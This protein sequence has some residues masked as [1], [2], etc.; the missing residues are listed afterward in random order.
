MPA[1]R[2]RGR[3]PNVA[4]AYSRANTARQRKALRDTQAR[5]LRRGFPGENEPETPWVQLDVLSGANTVG[6]RAFHPRRSHIH[7]R[8]CHRSV[9]ILPRLHVW[10]E[11]SSVRGA[12]PSRKVCGAVRL[13]R[14]KAFV[15]VAAE[16][17]AVTDDSEI[18]STLDASEALRAG[19]LGCSMTTRAARTAASIVART[20]C[21]RR[22]R[23]TSGRS[24]V[25]PT[26]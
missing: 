3:N 8:R 12:S 14:Q 7:D 1:L 22:I 26:V 24:T 20:F 18:A 15:C 10:D 4:R 5:R 23:F 2:Q 11:T 17:G 9:G 25:A 19:A 16:M 6:K 21:A 13:M